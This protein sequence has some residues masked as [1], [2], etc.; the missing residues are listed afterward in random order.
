[1]TFFQPLLVHGVLSPFILHDIPDIRID[2]I[3]VQGS[4]SL[5]TI[6]YGSWI[7]GMVKPSG[8]VETLMT[9]VS[10]LYS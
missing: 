7:T 10:P 8:N 9:K 5:N 1:M 3:P 4:A 2:L 6:P